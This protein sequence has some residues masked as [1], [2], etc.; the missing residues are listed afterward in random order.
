[1]AKP[2]AGYFSGGIARLRALDALLP[3]F[4]RLASLRVLPRPDV[5]AIIGWGLKPSSVR[6]RRFAERRRLPYISLE[7]GFLRSLGLGVEG[8]QP[9]SLVVDHQGIYYDASRPSDLED[10]IRS[11]SFSKGTLARSRH[12][13]ALLR[14]YRLAKYNHAP[15]TP[16]PNTER[17]RVLVVDQTHGDASIAFGGAS[18]GTFREML[19]DALARHPDAEILV[20]V[21][22]DVIAGKKRGHLL[23]AARDHSRCRLIGEDLNP[24]ALLDAV[25]TVHVVTSQLGFEALLAGKRVFCHG[26]PFFAGWGLTED[27][28]TCPRRGL[29]RSLEALFAAAYLEYSRYANPYTGEA[30]TL[31]ETIA[32]IAD[33]KRQ[34][35]RH[36]GTWL[37]YDFTSWKRRFIGDFLG[38]RAKVRHS[39]Q[40]ADA[41]I[42]T[43][44]RVLVWSNRVSEPLERECRQRHLPL[45]RMEDGFVRSVGLGV[46]L[47]RPLSLVLDSRGIY[48]DPT[49]P[50]DLEHLLNESEFSD[51]LLQRA[52]ALRER[53][54]R[55]KLSKYNVQGAPVPPLP[56]GRRRILVP[57]QVETDASIARGSPQI[58]T[59]AALLTA[60]RADNPDAC[61]LFK[62]HP[63]VL[64]GARLGALDPES[65]RL[66]DLEVGK[67]DIAALLDVVD[68]IHTM[69]SL[70]GFEGL[71]RGKR[72]TTYGMPFYAGWGLTLDRLDAP[73]RQRQLSLDALVAGTLLLYPTYVD[74]VTR[75]VCNAE[76]AV[77]LLEQQKAKGDATQW[78]TW[79]YRHYRNMFI[80]RR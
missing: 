48:Y 47:V 69:S 31:E 62:P 57:G 61:I 68:E 40:I 53:L 11:A 58:R 37:A 26:M 52:R 17:Q 38:P 6:A 67:T 63:D 50:S 8:F 21:H 80:G 23:E 77:A 14:R 22:P 79:L 35:D 28:Q 54:V 51:D 29:K 10:L 65:E 25:E 43:S 41:T 12:C 66:Y 78:T 60:V 72:V 15:D 76:T 34:R 27:R 4:E 20:K 39:A 46:D 49:R 59:N 30:A 3:E 19:D 42:P 71:L 16:W 9:H 45:W 13:M 33:Q 55:L 56:K 2:T 24:W 44:H 18:A 5:D 32:L 7:D 75:Q 64:S 73:R 36:A 74:P 70:T 1:M